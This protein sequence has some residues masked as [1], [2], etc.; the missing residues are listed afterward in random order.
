MSV[1]NILDGTI[2][3]GGGGGSVQEE[4][5][6]EKLTVGTTG[7]VCTGPITCASTATIDK[8]KAAT[9]VET[10]TVTATR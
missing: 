8:V 5:H 3:I 1:R 2:K 6:T 10:P 4:V 7:M 9:S